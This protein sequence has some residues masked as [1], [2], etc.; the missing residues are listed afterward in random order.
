MNADVRP[1]RVAVLGTGAIAQVVHLPILSQ[2]AGVEVVSVHDADGAKARTI[3][4]RFGVRAVASTPEEVW[5]NEEVDAVVIATPSH[6]HEEHVIAGLAAGKYVLC[7]KPLA[8]SAEGARRVLAADG[9]EGRLLVAM[10]Q[11]F[12]PD[13]AAL[14]QVVSSGTIGEVFSVS[15]GWLNRSV[16]RDLR[17]WRQR[18]ESAG[19][20]AF[21]DLGLQM[22]DLALWLLAA[23]E[24]LR[25]SAHMHQDRDAEVEDSAVLMVRFA[26]GQLVSLEV[27]WSFRPEQDR[28]FLHLLGSSGS[29][30]LA[31]LSV[32]RDTPEGPTEVT[33]A[34]PQSR[35]N[36]FTASYRMELQHFV[37]AARSGR[38]VPAPREQ[39]LLMRLVEGA[40]RSTAEG[41]EVEV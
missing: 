13:A 22:L 33:P 11:R 41:R 28:Q 9:A 36:P 30:S 3:A 16:S 8:L 15:A 7:E 20:G 37:D 39:E 23:P 27:T 1:L 34:V 6:L 18:K 40:Y 10:N 4:G 25:V 14:K 21:M 35:E 5:G 32:F 38:S 29:G 17:S 26:G 12:R 19:G 2:M 24:P 31:P